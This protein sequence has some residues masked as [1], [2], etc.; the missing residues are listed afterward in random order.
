MS[1]TIKTRVDELEKLA[2]VTDTVLAVRR[3]DSQMVRITHSGEELTLDEFWSKHPDGT[4]L[5][6]LRK[7][8]PPDTKIEVSWDDIDED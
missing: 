5:H 2:G 6:V 1:K 7:D 3:E 8:T 4:L